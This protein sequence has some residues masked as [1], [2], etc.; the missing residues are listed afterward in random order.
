MPAA[1]A[2]FFA[3]GGIPDPDHIVPA[4]RSEGPAVGRKGQG[5]DLPAEATGETVGEAK[6]AALRELEALEPE[7]DKA[8][9]RFEVLSEGERGL[10]GVGRSPAR[11]LAR[12]DPEAVEAPAGAAAGPGGEAGTAALVREVLEEICRAH[13]GWFVA[14]AEAAAPRAAMLRVSVAWQAR[15]DTEHDNLR[16][17]LRWAITR[18]ETEIALRVGYGR[19]RRTD[20][21]ERDGDAWQNGTVFRLHLA[22]DVA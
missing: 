12:V 2:K 11:V 20:P 19:L 9:V 17:A 5:Y 7:L 18:Q 15:L 13:A 10:L 4:P 16:A 22:V 1:L 21:T 14:M 3:G 6:W 8:A